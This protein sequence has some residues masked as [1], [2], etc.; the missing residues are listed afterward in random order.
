MVILDFL[1]MKTRFPI[2]SVLFLTLAM[3]APSL[4]AHG[5]H[6][7][8]A[9]RGIAGCAVPCASNQ[10]PLIDA[11]AGHAQDAV[12][13]SLPRHHSPVRQVHRRFGK[14]LSIDRASVPTTRCVSAVRSLPSFFLQAQRESGGP[15]TSRAPPIHDLA[16]SDSYKA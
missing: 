9:S 12:V 5:S 14:K 11:R 6:Q 10:T 1:R 13:S 15:N 3:Y 16:L 7:R 2:L 8:A 4:W